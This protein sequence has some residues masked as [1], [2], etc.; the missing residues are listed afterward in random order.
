MQLLERKVPGL[1]K[2]TERKSIRDRCRHAVAFQVKRI[3]NFLKE[4]E[5]MFHVYKRTQN[6]VLGGLNL[7]KHK[8]EYTTGVH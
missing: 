8:A 7:S 1:G 2:D 5:S 3:S 6:K 4:N